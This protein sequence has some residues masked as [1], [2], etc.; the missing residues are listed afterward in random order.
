VANAHLLTYTTLAAANQRYM[1]AADSYSYQMFCDIIRANFPDLRTSTPK[2]E[3]GKLLP[4]VYRI[5]NI[6]SVNDL[7]LE[8]RPMEQTVIDTVRSLKALEQMLVLE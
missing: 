6:K 4:E 2:G 8:Y 5:N 7:G 1:V 3:P